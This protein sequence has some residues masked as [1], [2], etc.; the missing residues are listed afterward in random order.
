MNETVGIQARSPAAAVD[1]PVAQESAT[2]ARMAEAASTFLASLTP[3]QR[4]R[5]VFGVEDDERLNW[6]Y[7]PRERQGLP[8]KELD[9]SQQKLAHA[10]LSSGLSRHGYAKAVSIM[11]L[12]S[13]LAQLEGTTR[14]FPRDP[15]LY[16]VTVFGIPSDTAPWG[17]RV[18]GHHVSVNML[19]AGGAR[20]A[21]T[22]SFFGA[23][24]ARVP[25]GASASGLVGYRVLA[26][27]EDLARRVLAALEGDAH[28][29]ALISGEA[30]SDITTKSEHRIRPDSPAGL[31]TAEMS[32]S[33]RDHLLAL[34]QEY[35]R[36]M[37]EDVAGTRLNRI[38]K[39]GTGHIHFAWAGSETPGGPHYY[40]LQGPSFLVE[41][42]NTQNNA[43]HI[44]TVW[45]DFDG[46][47][48]DDLLAGHYERSDH[49]DDH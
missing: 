25:E 8:F 12:E 36:R 29:R 6:H 32:S 16:H 30:P 43:N 47:W 14:R 19:V 3:D 35:V 28:A 34:V 31:P 23:N 48:G 41:Y 1:A 9:G 24:P 46:D 17:W 45:R 39:D 4:S 42:D 27:E 44:H 15:D 21:P 38:E 20:I 37:P 2:A 33:G 7:I 40:R 49:H 22:P 5:T 18:E 26:A 13:V 10:L 11:A